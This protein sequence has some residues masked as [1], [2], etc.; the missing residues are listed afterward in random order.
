MPHSG[1]ASACA[2]KRQ[3]PTADTA[4]AN[5]AQRGAPGLNP[6]HQLPSLH[7]LCPCPHSSSLLAH[8]RMHRSYFGLKAYHIPIGFAAIDFAG[9]S[10][11]G[12][13]TELAYD[14]DGGDLIKTVRSTPSPHCGRYDSKNLAIAA[15]SVVSNMG[16][17]SCAPA[18]ISDVASKASVAASAATRR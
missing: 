6:A 11:L 12:G 5:P 17:L 14:F 18:N 8:S 1:A 3:L 13:H 4:R 15:A 9:L 10:S 7:F 16:N 2:S